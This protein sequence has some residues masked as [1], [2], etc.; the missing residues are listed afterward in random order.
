MIFLKTSTASIFYFGAMKEV[1]VEIRRAEGLGDYQAIV[2]LEKEVWGYTEREDLAAVPILMIANRFGGAVLVAQESS[3]RII[4]F[5]MANLGWTREKKLFWWSHMTAVID[6]YRGR[7]IG[8]RLKM[9]QR[10]EALAAGIDEIH[11][12][13]DPL[14][15]LNAHFNIHKLG[16]IVREYEENVYGNSPSPLH[17]G[18]PTDRLVAEWHL[19]SDRGPALILRDIDGTPRINTPDS[20]PDL[21]L[22]T[23]PLLLEIPTNINALRETDIGQAKLWQDRVRTAC[24]H[25]FEA[26]Y[27]ITDFILVNE[28]RTQALYVL[29]KES[30]TKGNSGTDKI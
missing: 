30:K 1:D 19:D 4:G 3:G 27:V 18:L 7:D 9:R 6:E 10:E 16:A 22:E 28:P 17:R 25:Y 29:E 20:E 12:T 13:F 15:A 21:R 14:Q 23:S 24:C 2:E 8:H 11:W 26:G 5:S